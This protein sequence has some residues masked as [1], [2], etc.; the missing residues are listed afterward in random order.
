MALWEP[1]WACRQ[2]SSAAPAAQSAERRREPGN[3]AASARRQSPQLA[4]HI[5]SAARNHGSNPSLKNCG[6]R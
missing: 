4:S 1:V 2:N 6:C 3:A 5:K